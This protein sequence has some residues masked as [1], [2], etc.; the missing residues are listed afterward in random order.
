MKAIF[1]LPAHPS[2]F[3]DEY[4][5]AEIDSA[6]A[7][8]DQ[9]TGGFISKGNSRPKVKQE[10]VLLREPGKSVTVLF[11]SSG[12][13]EGRQVAEDQKQRGFDQ[14]RLTSAH[15]LKTHVHNIKEMLKYLRSRSS[16]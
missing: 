14:Y 8:Y 6:I 2:Y 4:T 15:D 5:Q 9:Q 13:A 1:Y 7:S 11:D 10:V 3:N 16:N 12:Y